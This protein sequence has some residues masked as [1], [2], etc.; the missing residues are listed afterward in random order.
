METF[1]KNQNGSELA[2]ILHWK[3]ASFQNK[4]DG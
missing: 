2:P 1:N 3:E 4:M